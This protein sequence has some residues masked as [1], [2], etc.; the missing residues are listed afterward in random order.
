M[1]AVSRINWPGGLEAM[2]VAYRTGEIDLATITR[3]TGVAFRS[4]RQLFESHGVRLRTRSEAL[5]RDHAINPRR[6]A[7]SK[8]QGERLAS[9]AS[10]L[11]SRIARRESHLCDPSKHLNAKV[12]MSPYER[13]TAAA[14]KDA[15]I[16]FEFNKSFPP[17]WLDFWLPELAIGV[18]VQRPNRI[19]SKSRDAAIR[20]AGARAVLYFSTYQI[21]HGR[22]ND[23]IEVIL[24]L[25]CGHLDP[26]ALGEYTMVSRRPHNSA[27]LQIG[28][29][30]FRWA[31]GPMYA[32]NCPPP[33]PM[34]ENVI[35]AA[36]AVN[37]DFP[38]RR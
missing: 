22:L 19:P 26:A 10:Q 2:F 25:Q 7:A 21:R 11:R 13:Q 15:G 16:A 3:K 17:F 37:P 24:L 8:A 12:G 14:L 29:H 20:E 18:E 34:C 23:L 33:P 31:F 36:N 27:Y 32:H 1:K 6:K 9:P 5:S 38:A 4:L 28:P 35:P 30:K